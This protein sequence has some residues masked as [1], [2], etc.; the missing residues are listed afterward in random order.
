MNHFFNVFGCL[1]YPVVPE[2][3]A[4]KCRKLEFQYLSAEQAGQRNK[5]RKLILPILGCVTGVLLSTFYWLF[6]QENTF[7]S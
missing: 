2:N 7:F 1:H 3:S 6:F 5:I 4:Y